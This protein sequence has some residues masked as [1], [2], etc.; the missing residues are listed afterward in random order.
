MTRERREMGGALG[1]ETGDV[2]VI[3][4][5]DLKTTGKMGGG[6]RTRNDVCLMMGVVGGQRCAAG[7]VLARGAPEGG[8]GPSSSQGLGSSAWMPYCAGRNLEKA[9]STLHGV[10]RGR[11]QVSLCIREAL[12]IQAI[13]GREAAM[14]LPR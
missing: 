12:P 14:D 6:S 9:P 11:A 4:D 2:F 1:G 7:C 13:P 8:F 3:S 10:A 5:K